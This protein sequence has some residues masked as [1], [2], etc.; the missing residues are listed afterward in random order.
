MERKTK[1]GFWINI[2]DQWERLPSS[3]SNVRVQKVEILGNATQITTV[4]KTNQQN[5][6]KQTL[7][8]VL[9]GFSQPA[10]L[11]PHWYWKRRE[12][13][14]QSPE[15]FKVEEALV[16]E[17]WRRKRKEIRALLKSYLR[18]EASSCFSLSLCIWT[19]EAHRNPPESL[20]CF[21]TWPLRFCQHNHF[22]C[23][24]F[25]MAGGEAFRP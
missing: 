6:T 11:T 4:S 24:R 8:W 5:E 2:W 7:G 25:G 22:N 21:C 18:H 3:I 1:R 23:L 15:A 9:P 14:F 16:P 12:V 20:L 19:W 13:I 17:G 10:G